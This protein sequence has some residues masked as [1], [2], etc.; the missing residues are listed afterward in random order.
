M[1]RSRPS[2]VKSE[3]AT[4][5]T[6][7]S[8]DAKPSAAIA[9]TPSTAAT[10]ASW[11]TRPSVS[12]RAR[13]RNSAAEAGAVPAAV[14]R[15]SRRRR[16]ASRPCSS[17]SEGS[18]T[19]GAPSEKLSNRSMATWIGGAPSPGTARAGEMAEVLSTCSAH[20]SSIASEGPRRSSAL[21]G[22]P[23]RARSTRSLRLSSG[24]LGEV[25]AADA[26]A[27]SSPR[28]GGP[29]GKMGQAMLTM[30]R[31]IG[32][33]TQPFPGRVKLKM[34]CREL[35]SLWCSRCLVKHSLCMTWPQLLT[36]GH[37]GPKSPCCSVRCSTLLRVACASKHTGL[38]KPSGSLQTSQH[39]ATATSSPSLSSTSSS[40]SAVKFCCRAAIDCSMAFCRAASCRRF[41]SRLASW[42][43]SA[44]ASPVAAFF[45]LAA[46]PRAT[47][48][49]TR[50]A[51]APLSRRACSAASISSLQVGATGPAAPKE[52]SKVAQVP[53][54]RSNWA[55][56]MSLTAHSR[57]RTSL[58]SIIISAGEPTQSSPPKGEERKDMQPEGTSPTICCEEFMRST[59]F[60]AHGKAK[61]A[62]VLPRR[63]AR[64]LQRRSARIIGTR[65]SPVAERAQSRA[66]R[67]A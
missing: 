66:S 15:P 42:L 46:A 4:Q 30:E 26:V 67:Q 39:N 50:C 64:H 52:V 2:N 8:H 17:S 3:V 65:G 37:S 47:Q 45:G 61:A 53:S 24:F 22:R 28:Y 23:W 11:R 54:S 19:P 18:S 48:R 7:T 29:A 6:K 16:L 51:M 55:V 21:R 58:S 38:P 34:S 20:A 14:P 40:K 43:C 31:H 60:V 32:Q 57:P 27:S 12:R 44:T 49:A 1:F 36:A 10:T 33:G 41:A 13:R 25:D 5:A 56:A 9:S 63:C 62:K 35:C 59:S